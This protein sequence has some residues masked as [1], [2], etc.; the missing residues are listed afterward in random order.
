VLEEATAVT[1]L[2][3]GIRSV[4]RLALRLLDHLAEG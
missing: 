1:V 4:D 3:N 2:S